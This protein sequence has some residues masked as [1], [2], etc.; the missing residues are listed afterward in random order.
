MKQFLLSVM[1]VGCVGG[2]APWAFAEDRVEHYEGQAVADQAEAV[3]SLDTHNA[4]IIERLKNETLSAADLE[5]IH[6]ISYSLETAVDFLIS[7][8]TLPEAKLGAVDEAVQAIH[9]HSENHHEQE[10]R[11]WSGK[12]DLAIADLENKDA[13]SSEI[14]TAFEIIIKDHKFTPDEI[15]APAGEKLKLVIHNQD[16][17]PEEFESDDFR[18]EKI[19][20]GNSSA[21]I[22][23]G[24]LKPGKYHFFGEFNLDQANGYLIVE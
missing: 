13:S 7:E 1:V 10:V 16:P 3:K 18:R 14:N 15:R 12:L 21:T 17:T 4:Q 22:Y 6:E 5:K 8:K 23:V 2:Y 24:P 20:A 19:I 9:S 11:E